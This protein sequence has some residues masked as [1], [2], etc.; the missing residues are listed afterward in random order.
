MRRP[1]SSRNADRCSGRDSASVNHP[2]VDHQLANRLAPFRPPPRSADAA[3]IVISNVIGVGIFTTPG[4]IATLLPSRAAILGV[5]ALGG[6]L[7]FAGALAL[8]RSPGQHRTGEN[9]IYLPRRSAVSPRFSTGWTSFVAGLLAGNR[10]RRL[11]MRS[12]STGSCQERTRADR[13]VASRAIQS[14]CRSARSW[15]SP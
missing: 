10:R 12:T 3:A 2:H 4:F 6:A 11:G 14:T 8:P 1:S 9:T 5:W 13:V 7:A 15:R